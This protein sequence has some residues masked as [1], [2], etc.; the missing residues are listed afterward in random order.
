MELLGDGYQD[1]GCSASL[2]VTGTPGLGAPPAGSE[3]CG[4]VGTREGRDAIQRDPA[5]GELGLCQPR[6][7]RHGQGPGPARGSGRCQAQSG[8]RTE[9]RPEERLGVLVE[10]KLSVTQQRALAAQK[11][12]P[13][14]G[15]ITSSAAGSRRGGFSPS[16]PLWGD[17][18]WSAGSS[19]GAPSVR[20]TRARWSGSRG[21][22]EAARR[23]GA[24]LLR[25]RAE[26]AGGVSLEEKAPGGPSSS[27]QCL[28]GLQES[29]GG[30]LYRGLQ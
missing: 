13:V 3:L 20:R 2:L 22:H 23:A 15:C 10:E 5:G 14:L 9:S 28:K 16:A 1:R 8:E 12:N 7:A 6:H 29:W 26:R 17:P 30:T 19:S 27:C 11:A 24:P 25:R 18:T 21:G 4:A